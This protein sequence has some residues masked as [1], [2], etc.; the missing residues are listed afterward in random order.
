MF[1]HRLHLNP[2]SREARRD[3]ADP[4]QLHSTLCRAF[5]G[6]DEP[7]P[8]NAFLWRLEP[9]SDSKG[10]SRLL[11]QSRELPRWERIGARGWFARNPDPALDLV[12]RL[13]LDSLKVGTAFRFRLRA[14]PCVTRQGKRLGLMHPEDQQAWI[15]R[16]GLD[17]HGFEI[18]SIP[19]FDM[20]DA[21][22]RRP[23]IRIS[24]EQMLHGRQRSGHEIRVFSVLFEGHLTV[25][26]P[27][28]F[29][30]AIFCGIGHAKAL[31]LGL[32]SVAPIT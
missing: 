27:I 17:Q 28:R 29:K 16:K 9:E 2:R 25:T 21:E 6:P 11:V 12:Q 31:G 10:N 19:G 32:L 7:C 20:I 5:S 4:Y 8:E 26:E 24:H 3:L 30:E 15:R 14:N 22:G 1:L 18:P 23:D 13:G